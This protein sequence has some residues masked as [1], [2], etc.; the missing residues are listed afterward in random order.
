[1]GF[2][3]PLVVLPFLAAPAQRRF[4]RVLAKNYQ[5]LNRASGTILVAI[6]ILGILT[7]VIPNTTV[8]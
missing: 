7:E 6:G 2:G 1:M 5:L 8:V 4:T 3:W